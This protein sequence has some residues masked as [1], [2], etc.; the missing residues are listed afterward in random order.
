MAAKSSKLPNFRAKLRYLL[1]FAIVAMYFYSWS[2]K[3][4]V[5][6]ILKRTS[7]GI[8]SLSSFILLIDVLLEWIKSRTGDNEIAAMVILIPYPR[9]F[10]ILAVLSLVTVIYGRART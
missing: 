7:L 10:D 3:T 4:Q 5:R 8:L 1:V 6:F 9:L 2:Y